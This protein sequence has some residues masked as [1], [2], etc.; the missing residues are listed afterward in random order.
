MSDAFIWFQQHHYQSISILERVNGILNCVMHTIFPS[1]V[2]CPLWL[3][4]IA[5]QS[6]WICMFSII[7]IFF[8]AFPHEIIDC[9]S[10][11]KSWQSDTQQRTRVV[12]GKR[13]RDSLPQAL[14]NALIWPS[15]WCI[16]Q[17]I[18]VLTQ[19]ICIH[20]WTWSKRCLKR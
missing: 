1:V 20:S 12:D 3:R 17:C 11:W 9:K 14:K 15:M 10:I 13:M 8:L 19:C 16:H 2:L 18:F 6:P 4:L 5:I 7:S